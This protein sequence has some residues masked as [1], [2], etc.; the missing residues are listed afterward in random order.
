MKVYVFGNQDFADDTIALKVADKIKD[1]LKNIEFVFVNPNED[2][3]FVRRENVV[4]LD[5]IQGIDEVTKLTEEDLDKIRLEK[6]VTAHDFDLA[7]QLKYLKKLGRLETFTII[8]I[9]QD[10][11]IDYLL[12]QKMVNMLCHSGTK[13]K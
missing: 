3:P 2:L 1:K 7:F 8:G 9:P 12:V 6:S 11:K 5:T 10:G 13:R 4:I